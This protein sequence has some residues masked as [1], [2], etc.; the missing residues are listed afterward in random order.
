[1]SSL[2]LEFMLIFI[3]PKIRFTLVICG[4]FFLTKS[5]TSFIYFSTI[6]VPLLL[7]FS[8]SVLS[9]SIR[10]HGL[11]H[12]RLPCLSTSHRACSNSCP[13]S[14][15]CH[16]TILSSVVPFSSFFQYFPASGS[17]PMSQYFSSG[18]QSIGI[19]AAASVLPANIQD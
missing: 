12:I 16:P 7:L 4:F 14:Q 6:T 11:Q 19:S 15:W 13:L 18:G 1:M 5:N 10:L 9:D 17:F 8:G 3:W 2:F